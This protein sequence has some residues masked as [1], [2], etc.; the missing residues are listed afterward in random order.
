MF[1]QIV[2]DSLQ[3]PDNAQR[4]V[5]I[6]PSGTIANTQFLSGA[7]NALRTK[8]KGS[9]RR[10]HIVIT[11]IEHPSI[12]YYCQTILGLQGDVDVTIVPP[13]VMG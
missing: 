13:S 8:N 1:K 5:V 10:Y 6:F 2:V 4:G 7:L 9:P 12:M 3:I 11:A